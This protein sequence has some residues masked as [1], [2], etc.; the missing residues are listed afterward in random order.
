MLLSGATVLP[1]VSFT[2]SILQKINA[3][4]QHFSPPPGYL[5]RHFTLSSCAVSL[6]LS[7]ESRFHKKYKY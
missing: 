7:V 4:A 3:A 6:V 5:R 2:N 1:F